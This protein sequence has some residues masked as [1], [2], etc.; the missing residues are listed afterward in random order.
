MGLFKGG[1]GVN[2]N[3]AIEFAANSQAS[4]NKVSGVN[5]YQGNIDAAIDGSGNQPIRIVATESI[6]N[7]F[8]VFRYSKFGKATVGPAG[9][10][11]NPGSHDL[12]P[13]KLKYENSANIIGISSE[14]T[15]ESLRQR[16]TDH[17]P[18][19][20]RICQWA[21]EQAK[22]ATNAAGPLYPYPYAI[23]DFLWCKYFL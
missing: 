18:S 13:Y 1:N 2:E 17:N 6:F 11:G 22:D 9:G 12:D 21:N 4:A 19:A 8:N 15:T 16:M 3:S 14:T 7:P 10:T 23:T 5:P 20:S